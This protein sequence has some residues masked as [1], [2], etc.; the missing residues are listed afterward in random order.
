MFYVTL[1]SHVNYDD[2]IDMSLFDI[3]IFVVEKETYL[4]TIYNSSHPCTDS[5]WED[6]SLD[7]NEQG[8]SYGLDDAINND[9]YFEDMNKK[10]SEEED[11]DEKYQPQGIEKKGDIVSNYLDFY[12]WDRHKKKHIP[13][14][15][16]DY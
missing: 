5:I 2:F 13:W 11:G 7:G 6:S 3:R 1:L 15:F 10:E 4:S 8:V 16:Q 12:A 9:S 14:V